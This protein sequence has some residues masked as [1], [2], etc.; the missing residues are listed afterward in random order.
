MSKANLGDASSRR[1]KFICM[2]AGPRGRQYG[3][4]LALARTGMLARFYTDACI[5]GT[6]AQWLKRLTLRCRRPRFVENLLGRTLPPELLREQVRTAWLY[7]LPRSARHLLGRFETVD[8]YLHRKIQSDR[9]GGADGLYTIFNGS[10]ELARLA[11][12]S[13]LLVVHDQVLNPDVGRILREERARFPG[14]ERQT[15]H[16]EVEEG[17]RRDKEMWALADRILAPSEF[18]R[19]ALV[20]LGAAPEKVALV[21][22]GIDELWLGRIPNPIQGRILFVGS[23]GLRKGSHYLAEATRILRSRKVRCEIV[24]VGRYDPEVIRRPEFEGPVY[25]GPIPRSQVAEEFL[26][27]D[28]FVHPSLSEGS[29]IAH[30]EALACGV[31]VVAS[32]NAGP[33]FT[34]GREG[35]VVAARDARALADRLERLI[36]DR[37]LRQAMSAAARERAKDLTWPAY[38]RR[39]ETTLSALG[40][41]E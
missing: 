1:P 25:L 31:P 30:L 11:K 5:T 27:A 28:V 29:A 18:T 14:I 16:E 2:H 3:I 12:A 36:L 23:V 21:E 4:P 41:S 7:S 35:Y 39:I 37:P 34:D 32:A 9:F 15:P 33:V 8:Q 19:R 20:S 17:I 40:R 38:Q 13:G 26:K 24:V 6:T 10:L 22:Y